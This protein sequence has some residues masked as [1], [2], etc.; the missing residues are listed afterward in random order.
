MESLVEELKA[1]IAAKDKDMDV[2]C[3]MVKVDG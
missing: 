1:E 3:L 2:R